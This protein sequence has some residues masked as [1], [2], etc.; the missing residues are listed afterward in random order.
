MNWN[1]IGR[2]AVATGLSAAL[3]L[4]ATACSRDY[5]VAFVY[6]TANGTTAAATQGGVV[7][8]YQVDYQSGALTQLAN[9]PTASGGR[10]PVDIVAAPSGKY[11]YVLNQNDNNVVEFA[12]G[13][14]GKLYPQNT[15][16]PVGSYPVSAAVDPTGAYLYVLSKFQPGYTTA[17]P[18]AGNITIFP[19]NTSDGSLDSANAVSAATGNNPTG[20]AVSAFK[21]G[22]TNNYVYVIDQE[23]ITGSSGLT[24]KGGVLLSYSHAAG[25]AALTRLSP[26]SGA[27]LN[28]VLAGVQPSAIA[29][30]PTARFV[31]VPDALSNQLIGYVIGNDGVPAAMVNGPFATG[32]LPSSVTVDPRGKYVYVTNFNDGSVSAYA[33]DQATGN[34]AA[35]S[36]STSNKTGTNPNCVTIEPALGIYLYT[37]NNADQT[38]TGLQLNPHNGNLENIQNTPFP[39]SALPSCLVAVANGE[40]ATQV[41]NLQ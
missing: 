33:I 17:S 15:Y 3:G 23:T 38:V 34:P 13:T 26:T 28:G 40:H 2:G 14:D 27:V 10:N 30:D 16:N 4:G 41:V 29:V 12:V 11:V 35:A 32:G 5:T 21:T 39:A 18:G 31:Y 19:I 1:A 25:S 8:G 6:A 7:D 20:I 9:S 22:A 36:G 37:T 24:S